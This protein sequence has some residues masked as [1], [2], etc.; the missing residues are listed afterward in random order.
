MQMPSGGAFSDTTGVAFVLLATEA[1]RDDVLSF[2]PHLPRESFVPKPVRMQD[3]ALGVA[4]AAAS[5]APVALLPTAGAASLAAVAPATLAAAPWAAQSGGGRPAGPGI[6]AQQQTLSSPA[7][8]SGGATTHAAFQSPMANMGVPSAGNGGRGAWWRQGPVV[9]AAPPCPLAFADI[10]PDEIAALTVMV[11]DDLPMN[12]KVLSM[13]LRKC[14]VEVSRVACNGVE[15]AAAAAGEEFSLIFMGAVNAAWA[16]RF[17]CPTCVLTC[18]ALDRQG[19]KIR[20]SMSCAPSPPVMVLS[21]PHADIQ[22]PLCGGLEA[23]RR[24]RA[25]EAASGRG[26]ALVYAVTAHATAED[27][28]V[29]GVRV[30]LAAVCLRTPRLSPRS[31]ARS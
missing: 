12:V 9:P 17:V 7:N 1:E 23:T 3:L 26:A 8:A 27:E 22:M 19:V 20:I 24:I 18:S 5:A 4:R 16:Y 30:C 15:A 28:A 29:R 14:G 10:S 11:V 21:R 25:L 6:F 13:L 2:A 31:A